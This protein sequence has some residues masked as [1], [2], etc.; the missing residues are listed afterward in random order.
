MYIGRSSLVKIG[1]FT[2]TCR[3]NGKVSVFQELLATQTCHPYVDTSI[4]ASIQVRDFRAGPGDPDALSE[5]K[6]LP[7]PTN[8]ACHAAAQGDA[9]ALMHMELEVL[10][11]PVMSC[12]VI[13]VLVAFVALGRRMSIL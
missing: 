13:H 6:L 7:I 5:R 2:H 12:H 4:H 11:L 1:M 10:G 9:S 3:E 8:A